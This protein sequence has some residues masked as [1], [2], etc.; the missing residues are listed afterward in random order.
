MIVSV[1]KLYNV[2]TYKNIHMK[3]KIYI[4]F[5][6]FERL[7]DTIFDIGQRT[8]EF[9]LDIGHWT[10]DIWNWKLDIGHWT[11]DIG[12][13]S[14]VIGH[15]TLV[16]GHWTLDFG[17]WTLIRG[18]IGR[19]KLDTGCQSLVRYNILDTCLSF[20][21][22]IAKVVWCYWSSQ[23]GHSEN[24]KLGIWIGYCN[25]GQHFLLSLLCFI[26]DFCH[27]KG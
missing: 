6:F 11:L 22:L 13:W 8:L 23:Y 25:I 18:N 15:W 2:I 3:K 4:I 9:K 19:L 20:I 24:W 17:H 27:P 1:C 5:L 16:I 21:P 26:F 10:F 14:L 7:N 12:H